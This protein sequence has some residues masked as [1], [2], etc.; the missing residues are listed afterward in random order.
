M[1]KRV[2]IM[3]DDDLNKKLHLIQA[4][5]IQSTNSVVSFSAVLNETIRKKLK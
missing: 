5:E 1:P 3:L 2:T 4:K